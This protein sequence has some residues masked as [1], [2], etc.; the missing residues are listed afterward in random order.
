M[1][2]PFVQVF[3]G[4]PCSG[5]TTIRKREM[6]LDNITY[7]AAVDLFFDSKV[8][9]SGLSLSEVRTQH[10][11]EAHTRVRQRAA[12][13]LSKGV[14][15]VW[16]ENFV[17]PKNRLAILNAV[18]VGYRKIMHWCD[19]DAETH[20]IWMENSGVRMGENDLL[21]MK[22]SLERPYTDDGWDEVHYYLNGVLKTKV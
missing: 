10:A 9:R 1:N 22:A 5:K 3:A 21:E 11:P 20:K 2:K 19:V 14:N 4:L 7:V 6:L 15:L 18:P 12:A 16:E 13:A 8:R 17:T